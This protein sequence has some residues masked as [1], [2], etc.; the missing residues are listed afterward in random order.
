MAKKKLISE[1]NYENRVGFRDDVRTLCVCCESVDTEYCN[2]KCGN[3]TIYTC[4]LDNIKVNTYGTCRH[5]KMREECVDW[6]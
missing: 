5:Q 2:T 6:D 3:L 4:K 1:K